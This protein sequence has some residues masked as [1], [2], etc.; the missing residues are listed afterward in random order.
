MGINNAKD[1]FKI[2]KGED[3]RTMNLDTFMGMLEVPQMLEAFKAINID[4]SEAKGLFKFLDLDNSGEVN[5]EEFID[6]CLRLS[7]P[8]KALDLSVL[9][10]EVGLI[11]DYVRH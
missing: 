1:L 8:A 3:K 4:V 2:L 5:C 7:G 11:K 6:G 10:R 9:M